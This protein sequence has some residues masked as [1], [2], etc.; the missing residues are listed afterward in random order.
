MA[1]AYTQLYIQCVFAPRFRC[2]MLHTEWSERLRIYITEI[3]RTNGHKMIAINNMPDH[4]HLF[5]G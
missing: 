3:A 1:N 5:V 2:A 4:L